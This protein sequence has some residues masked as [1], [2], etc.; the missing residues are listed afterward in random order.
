MKKM[1][2]LLLLGRSILVSYLQIQF[3]QSVI[4]YFSSS[5]V[6]VRYKLH[7]E[8]QVLSC[9]QLMRM[10]IR[11][12]GHSSKGGLELCFRSITV[13]LVTKS[14]MGKLSSCVY[15]CQCVCVSQQCFYWPS[16]SFRGQ[17]S[18]PKFFGFLTTLQPSQQ[19][20]LYLGHVTCLSRKFAAF[21][22]L[23]NQLGVKV[24][25]TDTRPG[26][27]PS[28]THT[29]IYTHPL[30]F[31]CHPLLQILVRSTFECP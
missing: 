15:V 3:S 23:G 6:M 28:T 14:Q 10:K 18:T 25:I 29:H 20:R 21:V 30:A 13:F 9:L 17:R 12:R 5:L 24:Y 16:Y 11:V 27:H 1:I 4:R 26:A 8:L 22:A 2:S 31:L 7:G 19:P